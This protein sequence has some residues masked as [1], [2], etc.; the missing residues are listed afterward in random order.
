MTN[1][2]LA[3]HSVTAFYQLYE[4]LPIECFLFN[5]GVRPF[6]VSL[7]IAGWD[8]DSETP[9]LYQ[10]DPSVSS[11]LACI[12]LCLSYTVL[13]GAYFAW[14][15]TA[16][17][18]NQTNGKTFLEKRYINGIL[19]RLVTMT[20]YFLISGIMRSWSWNYQAE[21]WRNRWKAVICPLSKPFADSTEC[22]CWIPQQSSGDSPK[23]PSG[24][25]CFNR[26]IFFLLL[27]LSHVQVIGMTLWNRWLPLRS[28]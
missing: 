20:D 6:G 13:Q 3:I 19:C 16:M 2:Y 26:D 18:K 27:C 14:K 28:P 11:F 7:L 12:V 17:G 4:L 23:F 8:E 22:F 5:R 10:C 15:A 9:Y 24:W 25:A 21:W 1:F